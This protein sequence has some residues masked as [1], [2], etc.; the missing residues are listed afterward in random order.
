MVA[1]KEL[2][3]PF[4]LK[5]CSA[6]TDIFW[7]SIFEDLAYGVCPMG[8]YISKDLLISCIKG[9]EFTF[10]LSDSEG[11]YNDLYSLLNVK[12][13]IF[14]NKEYKEKL[15]IFQSFQDKIK[16]DNECW[17]KIRKKNIKDL[18]LDKYIIENMKKYS[19]GYSLIKKTLA[20]IYLSLQFKLIGNKDIE[21]IQGKIVRING[22]DFKKGLVVVDSRIRN[23]FRIPDINTL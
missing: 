22:I 2:L 17:A 3:F 23:F 20:L 13:G 10:V 6:T 21:F 1:K 4:I 8:T 19:L 14:S 12:L 15:A 11:L 16:N 7:K 18:I 5:C 9:K